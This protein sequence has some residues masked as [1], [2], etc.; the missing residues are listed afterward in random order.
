MVHSPSRCDAGGWLLFHEPPRIW[1]SAWH[2]AP[3]Q[4]LDLAPIIDE[5]LQNTPFPSTF[6]YVCPEPV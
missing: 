6:P 3:K 5:H 4:R 2:H 1:L